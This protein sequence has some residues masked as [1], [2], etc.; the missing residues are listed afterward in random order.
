MSYTKQH[1]TATFMKNCTCLILFI[2][3]K[4]NGCI[5]NAL[6]LCPSRLF[7]WSISVIYYQSI[8]PQ[9]AWLCQGHWHIYVT[10]T[11]H[12]CFMIYN[13]HIA[14]GIMCYWG[15]MVFVSKVWRFLAQNGFCLEGLPLTYWLS[16]MLW[17]H[18]IIRICKSCTLSYTLTILRVTLPA[19]SEGS[20]K[21]LWCNKRNN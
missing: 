21:S 12:T 2:P 13:M 18:V 16:T 19:P 1:I 17:K 4:W 9:L 15:V 11:T 3:L 14:G 20:I 10:G 8:Y 5:V 6:Y 7:P